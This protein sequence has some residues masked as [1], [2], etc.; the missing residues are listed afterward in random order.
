MTQIFISYRRADSEGYVGRMYDYLADRFDEQNLFL[1]VATINAGADFPRAIEQALAQCDV[2]IAVIGPSWLDA[3]DSRGRRRLDQPDDYVRLEVATALRQDLHVI[4]A[5][6]Q[7]ARMP[8]A[9]E[10]PEELAPLSERNYIEISHKRFAYDM[11]KLV[12]AIGGAYG[13]VSVIYVAGGLSPLPAD[14]ARVYIDN[15]RKAKLVQTQQDRRAEGGLRI[16]AL[17]RY[18]P[19]YRIGAREPVGFMAPPIRVKEG[20]H[21]ISVQMAGQCLCTPLT[22][23]IRGGEKLQF[24]LHIKREAW[25]SG[26]LKQYQ[27]TLEQLVT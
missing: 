5:L 15:V 1:D 26:Q 18:A 11:D 10:L 23:R 14:D 21:T 19:A 8:R 24:A 3:T 9:S 16:P 13:Q 6:V 7:E 4:P 2:L 22:F 20:R 17:R 25:P 27:L 12:E